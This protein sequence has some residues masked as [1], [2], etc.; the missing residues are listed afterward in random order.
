MHIEQLNLVIVHLYKSIEHNKV[1]DNNI[2]NYILLKNRKFPSSSDIF[3]LF[4]ILG[5]KNLLFLFPYF[6]YFSFLLL[7]K[8]VNGG[9]IRLLS[10][11]SFTTKA[12]RRKNKIFKFDIQN[13]E[14]NQL[15]LKRGNPLVDFSPIDK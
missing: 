7:I 8:Y 12:T 1:C 14:F 4:Y 15:I 5:Q 11:I 13:A 2:V 6:F 10:S 9:K 3:I